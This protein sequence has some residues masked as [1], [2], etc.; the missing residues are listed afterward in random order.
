MKPKKDI[1]NIDDIKLMVDEFYSK[2]Q[3]DDILG[4][5][6][7]SVIQDRWPAHLEK[8]YRFWQTVLLEEHT[9]NGSPFLPH[10]KLPVSIEH[11]NH[12]IKLFTETVDTY[13]EGEK[14]ERAKWQGQRMADMFLSKIEY[15]K[16][17]P[18]IPLL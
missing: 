3:H 2:I 8:M 17:N 11:F 18:S 1:E 9:Y 12:W 5:I 10:A 15:Y 4:T 16:N 13:F 6:F 7:N 14:A